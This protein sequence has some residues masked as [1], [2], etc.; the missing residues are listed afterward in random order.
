MMPKFG[1]DVKIPLTMLWCHRSHEKSRFK[2]KIKNIVV[3]VKVS[4]GVGIVNRQPRHYIC[5]L[6]ML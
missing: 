1:R 6:F 3:T 4:G 2:I 5:K